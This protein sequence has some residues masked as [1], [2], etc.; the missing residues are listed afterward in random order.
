MVAGVVVV[1]GDEVDVGEAPVSSGSL[2]DTDQMSTPATTE[3]AATPSSHH[4]AGRRRRYASGASTSVGSAACAESGVGVRTVS[5]ANLGSSGGGSIRIVG[6]GHR[7][8]T[9]VAGFGVLPVS[10]SRISCAVVN[11]SAG[12]LANALSITPTKV[13][14]RSSRTDD[15]SGTGATAWARAVAIGLSPSNGGTPVSISNNTTPTAYR[16]LAGVA[17]RPSTCS[18]ARYFGVPTTPP[19]LVI[20]P[21]R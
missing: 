18:G 13:A 9:T 4:G 10:A 16:S 5:R 17:G 19:P 2:L 11:R 8:T 14:G 3:R 15:T 7:S 21:A 6:S 1:T 20:E 12:S